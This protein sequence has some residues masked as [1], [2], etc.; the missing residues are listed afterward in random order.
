[1]ATKRVLLV[2]LGNYTH[3]QTRHSIG[4]LL[5]DYIASQLNLTWSKKKSIHAYT[6]QS[7]TIYIDPSLS[8]KQTQTKQS[9]K[10]KKAK[11]KRWD[12]G[13]ESDEDT[14]RNIIN[15]DTTEQDENNLIGPSLPQNISSA[16][17]SP[18]NTVDPR[19]FKPKPDPVPL[20]LTLLKPLLLMN[21]SGKSVS[22]AVREL[23][24]SHT[25]IIIIHDDMQREFGKISIKNGGSANGHNGVKSVIDHLKTDEFRRLRIGIGRP[26]GEIND[27]THDIVT[28]FVLSRVPHNEMETYNSDI[29][30]RCKDE[31]F[32]ASIQTLQ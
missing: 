28:D 15:G 13:S 12:F 25:N 11:K 24:F 20:E 6:T 22:K 3:P 16:P 5:L 31:L 10:E 2:G 21:H 32:K 8:S 17:I 29:F 7:I 1:M 27:K 18:P 19:K 30:P 26:P 9:K 4:L 23:G 14:E